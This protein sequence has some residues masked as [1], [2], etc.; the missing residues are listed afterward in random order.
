[1]ATRNIYLPQF[2][3]QDL[4]KFWGFVQ[5][6]ADDECWG[7]AHKHDGKGY[8]RFCA[9][10]RTLRAQRVMYFLHY[11]I[12]PG[13][14]WVLHRCD[15]PPCIN[16]HHFFLGTNAD[17]VADKMKKGRHRVV[18][19]DE[20]WARKDRERYKGENNPFAKLPWEDILAIRR[21]RRELGTTYQ[22]L[23]EL[24]HT[25]PTHVCRIVH[26]QTRQDC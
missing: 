16:P 8:S 19:G 21:R 6:G 12:D 4:E 20:H 9:Q 22:E 17:N 7:W 14:L 26:N 2:T 1:M 5:R 13:E 11:G 18:S 15:H 23:A 10:D 3:P 25:S 24:Y